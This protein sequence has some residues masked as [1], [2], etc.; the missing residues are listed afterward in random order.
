MQL[1]AFQKQDPDQQSDSFEGQHRVAVL[2]P[3]PLK[4]PLDYRVDGDCPPLGSF[5]WVKVGGKV[6]PGV[7]WDLPEEIS[8]AEENATSK[9]KQYPLHKLK[10]IEN[11]I[12]VPPMRDDLRQTIDFVAHYT[13]SDPGLV[14]R[15]ALSTRQAFK[16]TPIK[17]VYFAGGE[18]PER[19]TPPR[20]RALDA[21]KGHGAMT[22]RQIADV[23]GVGEGVVR[24]LISC[25]TLVGIEQ[26]VDK[27]YQQPKVTGQWPTLNDEQHQAAT[28]LLVNIK[29][30]G[31]KPALLE[32]VTGSGKTEV[33][34]EAIKA[35]LEKPYHDGQ[36]MVLLPEIALTSQWLDRFE[37]R[38][39]VKPVVWHSNMGT[40]ERRRAWKGVAEGHARVVVGARSA[41]FLP[42][43]DLALIIV[44]EEHDPSFKQE[45]G[46]FYHARDMA[47][48][49]ASFKKIPIILASATPSYESLH[50][51]EQGKYQHL[52]MRLRHGGATL[53][54]VSLVDM[55]LDQPPSGRWI[56]PSLEKALAEKLEQKQQAMLF[57]NRRGY[58]PLT[59]C[60]TCGERL[61]SPHC[62][63]WLVEHRQRGQVLC[64]HCGYG[65]RTPDEC[66]ECHEEGSLVPC[67]PGVERIVEEV[68]NL[69]PEA[70]ILSMTSDTLPTT[71][72]TL[73]AIDQIISG[74]VD[75]IV[76]TQIVTKGYH[77]PGL[78]LVGVI[79]ADLGLKGG[80]LRA[81]ER[82]WQQLSQVAG[83][84]GRDSAK[85][86]VYIQTYQPDHPV[87]EALKAG[88]QQA[89]LKA[90]MES[91]QTHHMPPF[92]RLAA[93][94][95]SGPDEGLVIKAARR[96]AATAP[97]YKGVGVLGPA[98]A[99]LAL[100]RGQY[101]YR[102][103]MK[104]EAGI[105]LQKM[106][107]QWL[108]KAG[109]MGKVRVKVDIDP[110]SFF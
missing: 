50:N 96:L 24:G 46:V 6:S 44:D 59:L 77:F 60:R 38:F 90:D 91:R 40:A 97:H 64:H 26:G 18:I 81:G 9:T 93:L 65:M 27:K 61:T 29:E 15:M 76:G 72:E 35:V 108:E 102:L 54:D 56:S 49:R 73:A 95:V 21:V 41:L 4:G 3:M 1:D 94:I 92:G 98:P 71:E 63:S 11:I 74:S 57:L 87:N 80:D 45:E 36:V 5:V 20:Q 107:R 32:G 53:P 70:R 25:G 22:V 52:T 28:A 23:A 10:L 105:A 34:F 33:Y 103:L 14:L 109:K 75:I 104:A 68:G 16:A 43:R 86:N 39:G 79:D 51:V 12:D 101:R 62:T 66:P 8:G 55:R 31:F 110:Y 69:F 13:L 89:F 100:L 42:F 17:M 7:V 67:G 83:R 58:A 78:T 48:V 88:D 106:I 19:L 85:G 37:A 2:L 84:A 47:V 82:T 99:P 30:G